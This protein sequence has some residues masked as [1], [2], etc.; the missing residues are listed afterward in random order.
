[1][2][3]TVI[4]PVV[5]PSSSAASPEPNPCLSCGAC[6]TLFRVSFHWSET[7]LV[8]PDGVPAGMTE[9][10]GVHRVAMKGTTGAEPI[11]CVALCGTIGESVGCGIHPLRAGVC[12]DFA[13]SWSNGEPNERCDAARAKYGLAPLRPEDW[14]R[15]PPD[16]DG[17]GSVAA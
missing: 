1:M 6:C 14:Q 11:R 17:G 13:A 15:T 9:N 16:R 8:K 10:L 3:T 2:E 4:S 5:T 7:D 12:R